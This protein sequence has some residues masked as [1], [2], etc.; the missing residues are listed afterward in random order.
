MSETEQ[1]SPPLPDI[2]SMRERA[3]V[4]DRILAERLDTV[5][6]QIMREE[7]VDLWLLMSREYFEEPVV[8]SMLDAK[9]MA[10][11]RRTILIFYD[12]GDGQP[13][14]RLTVSRYGLAGLF[15]P[16]WDPDDQP[17]QWKAVADIIAQRDPTKIAI[18]FSDTTA[19]GDG[20]TLSQFRA[21]SR[22]LPSELRERIVS[23]E[24]LSVR[25]LETRIPAEIEI[26]PGIMRIA[27]SLIGEA[28]SRKVITPGK[29]T[30]ADVQWWY[31]EKLASLGVSPWFHPS[32]GIQRQGEEDMLR[33]DIVIQPGDLLWTDFGIT[34]LRLNT[35]TQHLVYVLKPGETEA[36]E[37][38]R[39]GLKNT[40][41][42]Q[43]ILIANF[44]MGDSGNEV[45]ARAR[46]Q[47]ISEG[48]DPSIYSH[49]IGSHGHGA[50]TAIG[51]WDNQNGDPRG[52]YR[53]RPNTAWSIELTTYSEVPEWD[54]Q[55]VD[56]RSEEDAYFDGETVRYLDGRQTEITLISSD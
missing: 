45:L 55:R 13:I 5:V 4:I 43:D 9:S 18:N 52:E 22:E 31:R 36:P 56:F 15:E 2:L 16:S 32:V 23:G 47:A 10:A 1:T 26:Y 38:L 28:F 24:T 12:P 17:N 40:N 51:F 21:M 6:P 19:F 35:D 14:E 25:W 8:R 3:K 11:R 41:R 29:T 20:M 53:I 34:Y 46:A 54:G 39:Q 37:G 44:R 49:P 48:L 7:D 33:G 30:A 50:G 42:T 27:H